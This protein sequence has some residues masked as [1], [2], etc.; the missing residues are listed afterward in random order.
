MRLNGDAYACY[1]NQSSWSFL[2]LFWNKNQAASLQKG[3]AEPGSEVQS[4]Y[5]PF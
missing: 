2:V 4:I 1:M 3:I 5:L